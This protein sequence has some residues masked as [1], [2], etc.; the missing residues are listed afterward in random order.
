MLN[1][2]ESHG[3]R[4]PGVSTLQSRLLRPAAADVYAVAARITGR[5]G[6]TW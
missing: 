4:V 6:W 5:G 1:T 3:P 2:R